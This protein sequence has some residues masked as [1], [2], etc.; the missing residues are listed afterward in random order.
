MKRKKEKKKK[1]ETPEKKIFPEIDSPEVISLKWS[2]MYGLFIDAVNSNRGEVYFHSNGFHWKKKESR[3]PRHLIS[4][5]SSLLS[6][7]EE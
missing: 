7:N 5:Y 4:E 6:R 1:K 2:K 3:L